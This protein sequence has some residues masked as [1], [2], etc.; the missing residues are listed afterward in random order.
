MVS[1]VSFGALPS[2]TRRI[3]EKLI[4]G[5][6]QDFASFRQL[7]NE[8]YVSR[9]IDLR[10]GRPFKKLKEFIFCKL[11]GL[12]YAN[13]PME[14][15]D[16]HPL[17]SDSFERI[18]SLVQGNNSG[19]TFVHC[20]SGIHRSILAAAFEEF[21]EGRIR[22]FGDLSEFLKNQN[23]FALN[24]KVRF[25]FKVSLPQEHIIK[26]SK[27]LEYQKRAFWDMINR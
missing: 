15:R 7:R 9:V 6:K 12:D 27:N 17:I 10:N 21:K 14:L 5:A 2:G 23:Y 24:K 11:L 19:R 26:R 8:E 18:H 4:V 25:G 16:R 22:T 20:N 1:N 13:I 3:S